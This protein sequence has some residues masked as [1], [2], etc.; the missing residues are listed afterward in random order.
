MIRFYSKILHHGCWTLHIFPLV[1]VG[2]CAITPPQPLNGTN[3]RG[4][5]GGGFDAHGRT[6]LLEECVVRTGVKTDRVSAGPSTWQQMW[7]KS[8][9]MKVN[10]ICTSHTI[11][12][13]YVLYIY[14]THSFINFTY[15]NIMSYRWIHNITNESNVNTWVVL[16]AY[17]HME[18]YSYRNVCTFMIGQPQFKNTPLHVSSIHKCSLSSTLCVT[19]LHN[20]PP[21]SL[22]HSWKWEIPEFFRLW[23]GSSPPMKE[24]GTQQ[25]RSALLKFWTE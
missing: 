7:L 19:F 10:C 9:V 21:A 18:N 16:T 23:S 25:T 12:D 5:W 17:T 11:T 13:F 14:N 15:K 3:Y 1:E 4:R 2:G 20:S 24:Q 8:L 22:T 6:A